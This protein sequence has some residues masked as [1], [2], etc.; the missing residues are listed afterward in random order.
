MN[1]VKLEKQCLLRP[2]PFQRELFYLFEHPFLLQKQ[3]VNSRNGVE[4]RTQIA[5]DRFVN[6]FLISSMVS[7]SL[8]AHSLMPKFNI[9][10][11]I[12]LVFYSKMR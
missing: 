4:W 7:S 11:S 2:Q 1:K 10:V 9:V 6:L 8:V 3:V 5:V 12:L